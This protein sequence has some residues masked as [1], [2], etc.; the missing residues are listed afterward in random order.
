[1]A[2]RVRLPPNLPPREPKA[3]PAPRVKLDVK[4]VNG[5]K[6]NGADGTAQGDVTYSK[7]VESKPKRWIPPPGPGRPA[8]GQNNFTKILKTAIIGAAESIGEDGRGKGGTLGYMRFLARNEPAVF[9][10]L[11]KRIL[12]IQ[13]KAD[14]D[15]SGLAARMLQTAAAQKSLLNGSQAPPIDIT[16]RIAPPKPSGTDQ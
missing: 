7:T 1:M 16:P 8:G 9:A 4:G 6:P 14:L 15:A 3:S 12:P 2:R 11:L 13:V 10:G 5:T